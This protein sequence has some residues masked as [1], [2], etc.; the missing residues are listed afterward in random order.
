MAINNDSSRLDA[1]KLKY[2]FFAVKC[3]RCGEEF[4]RIKMWQFKRYGIN[5]TIHKHFY[6]QNCMHSAKDVLHEIDTDESPFG[7]AFVDSFVITKKDFT[8]IYR[9]RDNYGKSAKNNSIKKFG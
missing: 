7:I 4:K 6:C 3:E 8:R 5:K 1:I 9:A 2:S